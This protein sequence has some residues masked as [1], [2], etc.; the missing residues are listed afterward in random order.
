MANERLE[1]EHHQVTPAHN[2]YFNEWFQHDEQQ[3]LQDIG[4]KATGPRSTFAKTYTQWKTAADEG[5]S[6]VANTIVYK[7]VEFQVHLRDAEMETTTWSIA[8]IDH[9]VT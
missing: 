5:V 9:I 7:G 8:D 4:T 2:R 3:P 6:R 1:H